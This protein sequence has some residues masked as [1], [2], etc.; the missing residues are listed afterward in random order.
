MVSM[1]QYSSTLASDLIPPS[2]FRVIPSF[3]YYNRPLP[4]SINDSH[5]ASCYRY[6]A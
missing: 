4:S 3:S 5:S 1:K 6:N 2:N